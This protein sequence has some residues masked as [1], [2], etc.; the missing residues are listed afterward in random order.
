MVT[1]PDHLLPSQFPLAQSVRTIRTILAKPGTT[2]EMVLDPDYWVH[3]ALGEHR[4]SVFKVHDLVE[5]LAQDGSFELE[6]R[7]VAVDV[8]GYWVQVRPRYRWPA[9]G[10]EI[11]KEFSPKTWPDEEGYRVEWSG[12]PV[13]RWRIIDR[14]GEVVGS[15]YPTE[16]EAAKKLVELKREKV[17]A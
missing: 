4:G 10:Q 8:R 11:K 2:I 7:V 9:E 13:H 17:A 12:S 5:I 3:G 16:A 15:R 14:V 6:V 1:I